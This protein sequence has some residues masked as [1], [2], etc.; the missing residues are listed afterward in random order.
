MRDSTIGPKKTQ[1]CATSHRLLS[2][3][4]SPLPRRDLQEERR[5]GS[6]SILVLS[7]SIGPLPYCIAPLSFSLLPS[8][9]VVT[10]D[11][12]NK[13]FDSSLDTY[14]GSSLQRKKKT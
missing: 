5:R 1:A 10:M 13:S 4:V 2:A 7:V 9:P 14:G 3:N 8:H 12:S 11:S 6:I